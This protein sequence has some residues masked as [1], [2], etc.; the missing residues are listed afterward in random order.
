MGRRWATVLLAA[1][2]TTAIVAFGPRQ[3]PSTQVAAPAGRVAS[4]PGGSRGSNLATTYTGDVPKTPP[5]APE[6][7]PAAPAPASTPP[8]PPNAAPITL[9]PGTWVVTI[10]INR[11]ASGDDLE[12]AVND[13]ND[14][15]QATALFGVP[16]DHRLSLRDGQATAQGILDAANW[17]DTHAGPDAVAVFFYAGHVR[18]LSAQTDALIG[19]DDRLV[20]NQELAGRLASLPAQRAWI[21]IAGCY[22][23]GFTDLLAPGR[24]LTAAAGADQLAYENSNF[25]RS[26]LV[27]Y[28]VRQAMFEGRAPATVQSAFAYAQAAIARDYPN[29]EPVEFDDGSGPLDLRPNPLPAAAPAAPAPPAPNPPAPTP[30]APAPQSPPAPAPASTPPAKSSPPSGSPTDGCGALTLGA[31]HCTSG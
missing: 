31:L 21:V 1:A 14:T 2:V 18:K 3:G 24:V 26:Y 17:L 12:G 29:R 15:D 6:P 28:M 4:N 13:A 10:G 5:A 19:A 22:G 30:P 7:A 25:G 20:T 9:G 16:G 11:Y 8:A 23:G 27:E